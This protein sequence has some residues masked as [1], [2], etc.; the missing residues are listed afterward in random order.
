MNGSGV[1]V[2]GQGRARAVLVALAVVFL[3]LAAL[4]HVLAR[5]L[6]DR[7]A[8]HWDW[9]GRADA[10][11]TQAGLLVFTLALLLPC[12]AALLTAAAARRE[13]PRGVWPVITGM[14]TLLG[15]VV[16]GTVPLVVGLVEPGQP[17]Q[18]TPSPGWRL[19]VLAAAAL[20]LA[21]IVSRLSRALPARPEH[22]PVADPLEAPDDARVSWSGSCTARWPLL[23]CVTL[24]AAGVV[25]LLAPGAPRLGLVMIAAGVAAS[26]LSH[27]EV[28]CDRRGLTVS[29]GPLRWPRTSVPLQQIAS[30]AAIEVNP[31]QWGGWG[32]RG[33]LRLLGRAAVV[34]GTGP[35]IRVDLRSGA[36][37]VVTVDDAATGAAVLARELSVR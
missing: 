4:P 17:W 29:Y 28:Y 34:L 23:V 20:A 1:Q 11:M 25:L 31:G 30:V 19:L 37:L 12:V 27:I 10:S 24:V 21:A 26:F 22:L 9:D 35:G 16:A 6:P 5:D 3:G 14:A 33:S 8:T 7:L 13:R 2:G 18:S 15:A 32:Y 36:T